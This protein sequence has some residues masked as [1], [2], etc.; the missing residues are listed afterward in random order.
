MSDIPTAGQL[1]VYQ[2]LNILSYATNVPSLII[3]I[4]LAALIL[5]NAAQLRGL[6]LICWLMIVFYIANIIVFQLQYTG[7]KKTY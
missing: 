6:V 1:K 2:N 7:T 4:G 3:W 5:M